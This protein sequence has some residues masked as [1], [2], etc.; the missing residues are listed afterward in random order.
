[1]GAEDWEGVDLTLVSGN[2]VTFRQALYTAYYIHRP[3]VPVEVLGRV[4]PSPD[5]GVIAGAKEQFGLYDDKGLRDEERARLESELG[6]VAGSAQPA[7]MAQELRSAEAGAGISPLPESTASFDIALSEEAATQVAFH[8]PAPVSVAAG[9]SIL[10]PIINRDLPAKRVGH[11]QPETIS[12]YPLAA[13]RLTNDGESGL[14]PGVITLYERDAEG[15][16]A[17]VGDARLATL[18][19][20]EERLV[21]FAVDQKTRIDREAESS[22]VISGGSISKGVFHLKL[23]E[24]QTTFYQLRAP[25]RE[26]RTVILDH[27]RVPGWE[28]VTPKENGVAQTDDSY[29]LEIVLEPESEREVPVVI[30]RTITQRIGLVSLALPQLVHFAS[31]TKLG[32]ELRDAFERLADLRREVENIDSRIADLQRERDE[33]Y[34]EQ[35]RIRDN[36]GRVPRDSDLFRRYLEKFDRQETEVESIMESIDRAQAQRSQAQGRLDEAI[37]ALE[38]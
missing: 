22:Q 7:P 34:Q 9:D 29:R 18:P 26:R 21:A 6:E 31:T 37:Q 11:Y 36:M 27:A 24:R 14:P 5:Q 16:A 8:V 25:A 32:Q 30:E 35:V 38:I 2:P 12:N 33:I 20:G 28:L 4:L 23:I 10:V 13:V 17:Y 3:E 1:M 19:V 15:A